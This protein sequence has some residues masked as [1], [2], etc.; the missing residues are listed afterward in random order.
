VRQ[1]PNTNLRVGQGRRGGL[2]RFAWLGV[3]KIRTDLLGNSRVR[4]KSGG[5][6][7]ECK[8]RASWGFSAETKKNERG[9]RLSRIRYTKLNEGRKTTRTMCGWGDFFL[10]TRRG[11]Q[12]QK[13]NVTCTGRRSGISYQKSRGKG[14]SKSKSLPGEENVG[15]HQRGSGV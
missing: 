6:A 7:G 5:G 14:P 3:G 11:Q 13:Q 4:G 1:N 12:I 10:T 15:R 8:Y 9:S 2:N